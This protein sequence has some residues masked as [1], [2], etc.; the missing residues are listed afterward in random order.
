MSVKDFDIKELAVVVGGALIS[1]YASGGE[2][3]SVTFNRELATLIVGADGEAARSKMN[4][5]SAEVKIR[6]LQSSTYNDTFSGYARTRQNFT[7]AIKDN[8]GN[9]IMAAE[10][11]W[12]KN[13][14][15][16]SFGEEVGE[17]EWTLET[18]RLESLIGG[19]N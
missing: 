14:P 7:L 2:A 10:T 13:R 18:D 15:D 11:A 12:V 4:D 17:R 9:T 3:V 5:D 19:V 16:V 8:N 6:L 1:G